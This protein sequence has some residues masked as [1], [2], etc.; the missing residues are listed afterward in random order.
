MAKKETK[1]IAIRL[2]LDIIE[3]LDY[4]CNRLHTNRTKLILEFLEEVLPTLKEET[5]NKIM[6]NALFKMSDV[7][8]EVGSLFDDIKK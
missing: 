6:K 8:N 2:P 5:P 7:I 3:D 4:V 1:A